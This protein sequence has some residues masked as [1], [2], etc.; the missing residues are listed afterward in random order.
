MARTGVIHDSMTGRRW[1]VL[2]GVLALVAQILLPLSQAQAAWTEDGLFPPTCSVHLADAGDPD[3]GG[4]AP[5]HCPLCQITAPVALEP[6]AWTFPAAWPAPEVV[7]LAAVI[8]VPAQG[9]CFPASPP[10]GPPSPA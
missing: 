7:P 9:A 6:P 10:R 5:G 4:D 3:Q 1:A 2:L 8:D